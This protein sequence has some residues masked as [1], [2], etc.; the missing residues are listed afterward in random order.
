L[1]LGHA[2]VKELRLL[3]RKLRWRL[4]SRRFQTRAHFTERAMAV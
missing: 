2:N 4:S 1:I 3:A